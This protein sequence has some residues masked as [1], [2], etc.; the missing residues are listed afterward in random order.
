MHLRQTSTNNKSSDHSASIH[1]PPRSI[2]PLH[3]PPWTKPYKR[4]S[5]FLSYHPTAS[6][7]QR[8]SP[9]MITSSVNHSGVFLASGHSKQTTF[10]Y[11]NQ[12]KYSATS[13]STTHA[14]ATSFGKQ[15]RLLAG[16]PGGPA[17]ALPHNRAALAARLK[18][19]PVRAGETLRPLG[20]CLQTSNP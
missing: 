10:F 3:A 2:T 17:V 6:C 14:G 12:I 19:E 18:S 4:F 5:C 9:P 16:A 15:A 13:G 11:L 8:P 7:R 20:S 1:R